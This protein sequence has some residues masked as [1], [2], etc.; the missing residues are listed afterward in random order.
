[1]PVCTVSPVALR[2]SRILQY[3]DSPRIPVRIAVGFSEHSFFICWLV[4]ELRSGTLAPSPGAASGLMHEEAFEDAPA[5]T[6]PAEEE[7]VHR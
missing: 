3:K 6:A 5:S 2:S 4:E 7:E 1:M